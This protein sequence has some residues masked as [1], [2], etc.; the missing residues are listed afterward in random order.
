MILQNKEEQ[1]NLT[2]AAEDT[3][4]KQYP[5]DLAFLNGKCRV[6]HM[7]PILIPR[8]LMT[9][10]LKEQIVKGH[11]MKIVSCGFG[12]VQ[13]AINKWWLPIE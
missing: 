4:P 10:K 12:Q 3:R 5:L 11:Q 9:G 6:A 1:T 8:L 7:R 13:L 2:D